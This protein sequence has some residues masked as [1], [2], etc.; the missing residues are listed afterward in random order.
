MPMINVSDT[1]G[2]RV[3]QLNRPEKLNALNLAMYQQLTAALIS[4]DA[5]DEIHA[6]V[7]HG[8]KHCFTAGNDVGDFLSSGELTH[9]HPAVQFLFTLVNLQKP[10]LA[11]VSGPAIGIGTT[12]LLH[13]DL[14]F[15]DTTAEFQLPF[16]DLALVPE[17]GA[18]MLLPQLVGYPRAA[19]LLLTGER[20][21]AMQA[22]GYRIINDV[23]SDDE[24]LE[25][26]LTKAKLIASKPPIAVQQT[27][28]LL[29][30]WKAELSAHMQREL[31]CFGE[32]LQ[33]DEAKQIFQRFLL[34]H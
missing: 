21:S 26:T 29:K 19:E 2:V 30:P 15:A 6:I 20:F 22:R 3:I 5:T 31:A 25:H 28:A 13:C 16:V 18:S 23:L 9:E 7:L 10:L 33:S 32:R 11:A 34:Q 24:L 8:T 1:Y 4:A 12:L 14:V 17:A 27:K